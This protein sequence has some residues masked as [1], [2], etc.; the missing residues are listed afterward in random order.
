MSPVPEA[1]YPSCAILL[2][3]LSVNL[4][5]AIFRV[6]DVASS[7][8]LDVSHTTLD[9]PASPEISDESP[10]LFGSDSLEVVDGP[11]VPFASDESKRRQPASMARPPPVVARSA[12]RLLLG[13]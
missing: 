8:S 11:S 9:S 2:S 7:Q 5:W 13:T 6:D 1:S 3:V 4:S 12:R 10:V